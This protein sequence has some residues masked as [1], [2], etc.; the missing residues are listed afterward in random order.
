LH[1][2]TRQARPGS[3]VIETNNVRG[4]RREFIAILDGSRT[5]FSCASIGRENLP[6]VKSLCRLPRQ[7]PSQ[8]SRPPWHCYRLPI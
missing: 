1:K 5:A 2:F 3:G 6:E 7:S 8:Q 4:T